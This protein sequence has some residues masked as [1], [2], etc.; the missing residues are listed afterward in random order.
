MCVCVQADRVEQM[1]LAEGVLNL[2]GL[3]PSIQCLTSNHSSIRQRAAEVVAAAVQNLDKLKEAAHGLG[4]LDKLIAVYANREE[5][6]E[7]RTKSLHAISALVQ[8]NQTSELYFLF[9][10]VRL[11]QTS[12]TKHPFAFFGLSWRGLHHCMGACLECPTPSLSE[13]FNL[14]KATGARHAAMRHANRRRAHPPQS[15][16]C[17]VAIAPFERSAPCCR[18]AGPLVCCH[19]LKDADPMH[20]S[21]HE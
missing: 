16:L 4:A 14:S 7:T 15:A 6:H 20:T 2:G 1:D 17:P 8:G 13:L 11:H 3:G 5:A 12:T 19:A 9:N 10:Q 18:H 21:A